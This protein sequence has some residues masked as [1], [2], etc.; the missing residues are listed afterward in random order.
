MVAA[1][2]REYV[3]YLDDNMY[4]AYW[5]H[6]KYGGITIVCDR[7][8]DRFVG[9]IGEKEWEKAML[10]GGASIP[11]IVNKN[12]VTISPD[13]MYEEAGYIYSQTEFEYIPVVDAEKN[14]V[15]MFTRRRAFYKQ[16]FK[17]YK[18]DKMHYARMIMAAA[19]MGKALGKKAISAIEFGVAGGNGLLA[20]QFHAREIGRLL[21]IEIQV[22]GFDL[23]KGLPANETNYLDLPFQWRQG[24][25]E[26]D[27]SRLSGKLEGAKLI[28]GD[29]SETTV[30]FI[31]KYDPAPIG[32]ISV[33]VD[34]YTST[35]PI[36]KMIES[37]NPQRFLP[38]PYIYFDDIMGGYDC[39]GQN[40]ALVEFNKRNEGEICISP[41][42]TT[43]KIEYLTGVKNKPR[44][45]DVNVKICHFFKHPE[46]KT[47]I[48]KGNEQL[49]IVNAA[50]TI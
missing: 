5:N 4:E 12:C 47:Y 32:V 25:F 11:E 6:V 2:C 37:T 18:L 45:W 23:E 43:L 39:V 26:M 30:N 49:P 44:E 31:E 22:Y 9:V 34:L 16:Y 8:N 29:V 27:F 36:L 17:D 19:T 38:R 48:R 24:L 35:L 7:D 33:D 15:D 40:K 50:R 20:M 10:C 28:L 21:D 14:V 1:K 13:H 3:A 41:E 42:G 46:Y